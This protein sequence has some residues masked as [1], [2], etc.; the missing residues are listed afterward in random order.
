MALR[1]LTKMRF[2]NS[3][4][5]VRHFHLTSAAQKL[6]QFT[7]SD[8]GEGIREVTVKE[9]FVKVGDNVEQFEDICLVES[10]KASVTITSRYDGIIKNLYYEVGDIA[11]V[12]KPLVDI[13]TIESEQEEPKPDVTKAGKVGETPPIPKTEQIIHNVD[14]YNKKLA[15]PAVRRIA[16]EYNVKLTDVPGSGKDG[17]IMKED[18]L[19]FLNQATK[20]TEKLPTD[21]VQVVP[22]GGEKIVPVSGIKKVMVRTMIES[23]KIPTFGYYDEVNMTKLVELRKDIKYFSKSKGITITY[24][25]FFIKAMS[26]CIEIYPELNSS[27]DESNENIIIKYYHNIGVA[28]DTPKGLVVPNIKNVQ[29]LSI[30]QINRELNTLMDNGRN[31]KLLPNDMTKG[32]ISISNIG[33]I[34][35]TYA[36][37]LINPP[38]VCILAVGK[39]RSVPQFNEDHKVVHSH[40]CYL[41]WTADHRII[42]G[43]TMAR[44]SN[45]FK[46]YVEN[47]SLLMLDL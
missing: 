23:S 28:V 17:R 7:L 11:L 30:A 16:M 21:E 1:L 10:D 20:K 35:G 43:A 13:D 18:I 6:T 15:T 42:D 5:T 38:E 44:F 8:I 33:A 31:G 32:T 41:S 29:N 27:L 25:P 45:L 4:L 12:G 2:F 47:P 36:V 14:I 24:L 40:V 34:G 37:P 9:W 26:K 3:A 19:N 22:T 46:Q 39:I